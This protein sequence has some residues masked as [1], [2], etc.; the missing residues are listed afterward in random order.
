MLRVIDCLTIEHDLYLVILAAAICT[1]GSV[2]S[3][4][5]SQRTF[6]SGNPRLWLG[7]LAICAGSTAWATHFLAM[8][9][10]KSNIPTTYDPGLTG[11][12]LLLGIVIIGFGFH[13]GHTSRRRVP[14]ALLGGA[15]VGAGVAAL[16][17]VGM[18][19]VRM[20][21]TL[22]YDSDLVAWSIVLGV[23]LGMAAF[24]AALCNRHRH[25]R[26][27]GALLLI[28][29]TITLH[30]TGMSAVHVELGP[31]ESGDPD[32]L[33]RNVL[34][35]AV[36]TA[37]IVLL[38]IG[39]GGALLDQRIALRLNGEAARFRTLANGAMEG[40]IVQRA[41]VIVDANAAARRMF[42]LERIDG[43][44]SIR[45][46]FEGPQRTLLNTPPEE[47]EAPIELALPGP[48]GTLFPA[49]I[50]RRPMVLADGAPGE[51]LAIRDLTIRKASEARIEHLALHDPLTDLPNRRL[52]LELSNK[53]VSHAGRSGEH[54]AILV[55]DLDGFKLVNDMH[56]HAAG[57]ELLRVVTARIS[58]EL[59]DADVVARFG[60][61]EFAILQSLTAQP[62]HAMSLAERLLDTLQAPI[63]VTDA[64]VVIS[65][66]IGVA[67]F[68]EDGRTTEELL[69][70]ADTAMYRA[71]ADGKATYRFFEAQMD[72]ALEARRRLEFRL[73]QAIAEGQL[74]VAFQ[75]LVSSTD[76]RP[77]G[78]EA[79]VRWHDAELGV[80]SPTDFIPVAEE[81]G[82]ILPLGAFVLRRACQEA[83]RWSQPLRVAVNLSVVQFRRKGLVEL[84]RDTLEESGLPGS[85]LELEVTESLLIDNRDEAL[86]ILTAL[87]ALGVRIAMDDFGTG[88]SSL[89]YLQSFPFDK[90]KIDR[91]F[92]SDLE[93]DSQNASIV[94]A[95]ASMGKSLQMRVVAEG[96]ETAGQAS[97][98]QALDCDELQGFMIARPMPAAQ[99]EAF[100]NLMAPTAPVP[101]AASNDA[102]GT[103]PAQVAMK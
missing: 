24:Y 44:Q 49:E 19:A 67:L 76:H 37:T 70:N 23:G 12:S 13:L 92:V 63:R 42:G 78:F 64:E 4:L 2:A 51:L 102:D 69:R 38:L 77:V 33:S 103:Q 90:I 59:R 82:L 101:T 45:H 30:F 60:G 95:V 65:A 29:T 3:L 98:L 48:D 50:C 94:R 27:I 97:L 52:F 91:V 62:H 57:D 73:R 21:G 96:V 53:A 17:H 14:Q 5:V 40:L 81:T 86:R 7:L 83:M 75:P 20:P 84:V 32:G 89:S 93:A 8:L 56:G 1:F 35:F 25:A 80:I 41:G 100:L 10:Y 85:R 9:G 79:L 22:R 46:W 28:G 16:H 58:D 26:P 18:A 71:K 88:Y 34:A 66:S 87:K 74:E 72:A 6:A 55:I 68:P 11:L 15:V 99:V 43:G 61:D 36:V 47:D 39:M 31:I 54:F